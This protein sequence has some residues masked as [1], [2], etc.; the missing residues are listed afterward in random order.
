MWGTLAVVLLLALGNGYASATQKQLASISSGLILVLPGVTSIPYKGEPSGRP[1]NISLQNV[2]TLAQVFKD[3]R[4]IT[5]VFNSSNQQPIT[6][7]TKESYNQVLGVSGQYAPIQ[8]IKMTASSRFINKIDV[9]QNQRVA[10][11]GYQVKQDLFGSMHA[12]DHTIKV[13][14]HPILGNW[15]VIRQDRR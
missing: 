4:W 12:I 7:H 3:I 5:P 2:L 8:Q 11:I 13:K 10:F 6:Y 1:I 15:R 9:Q 14:W